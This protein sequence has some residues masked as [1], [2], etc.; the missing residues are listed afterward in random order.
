MRDSTD[1]I[2]GT[3]SG[4]HVLLLVN[5]FSTPQDFGGLRTWILSRHLA[6][7]GY[8]VTVVAPS[9]DH[10]TGQKKCSLGH[11]LWRAQ[12]VDSVD[13]Y[14]VAATVNDRRSKLKRASYLLSYAALQTVLPLRLGAVDLVLC[15]SLPLTTMIAAL[16]VARSKRAKLLVDIRDLYIDCALELQYLTPGLF[17]DMMK[18]CE[19]YIFHKAN[20]IVTVSAGMKQVLASVGVNAEK[21][22]IVPLGFDGKEARVQSIVP[23]TP[24]RAKWNLENKFVVAYIGMLGMVSDI[25]TVLSAAQ[26]T[27]DHDDIVYV[28]IGEG[29]RE[30]EYRQFAA[31]RGLRCLFLGSVSKSEVTSAFAEADVTVFALREGNALSTYLGNKVF[32]S[33]GNGTPMIFVGSKGD[34]AHLLEASGGG[35]NVPAGDADALAQTIVSLRNDPGAVA[36]MGKS[37]RN[38]IAAGLTSTHTARHF[39]GVVRGLLRR[40]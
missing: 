9:V 32:D 17:T 22:A 40:V 19:R 29:Q 34:A 21:I 37:G 30:E 33:L 36:S 23:F 2:I 10:R 7:V 28:F 6:Q 35:V 11:R 4:P 25:P 31:S 39:E 38:Y 18:N 5:D 8:K 27:K 16:L 20:S 3:M 1:N 26:K 13:V 15:T 14:W 24:I 12:R